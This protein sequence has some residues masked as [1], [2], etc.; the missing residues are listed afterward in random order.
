MEQEQG[1]L[2][3]RRALEEDELRQSAGYFTR[4]SLVAVAVTL[5]AIS[6]FAAYSSSSLR[7]TTSKT[8]ELAKVSHDDPRFN[9]P[10]DDPIVQALGKEVELG[11]EDFR[12][13]II[14]VTIDDMGYNDIGYAPYSDMPSA[15]SFM[16]SMARHSVTFSHY[17]TQPSCTPSRST[18]MSGMWV[19]KTGYQNIE[20]Q[21]DY[22]FG[23]PKKFKLMPQHM[24]EQGYRTVGF[25]KWNIGHCS[26]DYQ[27]HTRGFDYFL[28][29]NCPGHGYRDFNC[30]W[31]AGVRDMFEAGVKDVEDGQLEHFWE[32]G[33]KYLGD[34]DTEIYTKG[35]VEFVHEHF[36]NHPEKRFFMWFAHHGM[37]GFKDSE[38]EPS[39]EMM[40]EHSAA[41]LTYL[42]ELAEDDTFFKPRLTTAAIAMN[43]DYSLYRL[44]TALYDH[45]ALQDSVILVHSDNGGDP[46]YNYGHPGNN[47]PLR[48]EKFYYFEG[49]VRVPAFMYAPKIWSS[50][51]TGTTHHGMLHHV[52]L[53]TTFS[54]L[55]GGNAKAENNHLDGNDIVASV[56]E[57]KATREEVV[58]S[59]P[60][61]GK[62]WK[63]GVNDEVA[64]L[65][66]G[67]YKMIITS[68]HDYRFKPMK[69]ETSE[70]FTTEYC[71][72][73]WY[74]MDVGK[75]DQYCAWGNKLFNV[76]E[77]PT[78]TINL[79]DDEALRP[80]K[81]I[82]IDRI[83]TLIEENPYDYGKQ[84]Y[85]IFLKNERETAFQLLTATKE[86]DGFTGPWNCY[87]LE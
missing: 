62:D 47:Y 28:G 37:H 29:Y 63:F 48:G 52:D 85:E 8:A 38:P 35:A 61:S 66:M 76:V 10:D 82:M 36:N 18:I 2:L 3:S 25:G 6:G 4:K 51:L 50:E 70:H 80:Q 19:H 23:M 79:W 42:R 49:G 44:C 20:V 22:G 65:R 68:P 84:Q 83:Y 15:T 14:L 26:M 71:L 86:R 54:L 64:A 7:L 32:T 73:G 74:E 39:E 81:Q 24:K 27:P 69:K 1:L 45:E 5:A 59:L 72:Y 87:T 13:N 11:A 34:Y 43:L 58:F 67:D 53:L 56:K 33:K 77:D 55:A 12:P 78:E 17:Y 75:E 40:A 60:R 30:G 46:D 31:Y 41:Y 21:W 16:N 57:G 9:I